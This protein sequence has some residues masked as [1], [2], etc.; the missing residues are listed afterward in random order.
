MKDWRKDFDK[1]DRDFDWMT[2]FIGAWFIFVALLT[3]ALLGGS[4]YT[5]YRVL[6]HF[7]VF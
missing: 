1:F 6:L 2:K 3:L 4:V 5:V 7:G